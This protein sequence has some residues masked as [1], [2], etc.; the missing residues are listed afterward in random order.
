MAQDLIRFSVA[1]P[2]NLLTRFDALVAKRGLAKNRSEVIRDLVREALA[3][4]ECSL[5][6]EEVI[7]TL[8]IVYDYHVKN[9][10]EKLD[11]IQHEF[12]EQIVTT[13]HI[14]LD[15]SSCMEVIILRGESSL[16]QTASNIILGTKGVT[17]GN[18]A[19]NSTGY[20]LY[21]S[22][23]GGSQARAFAQAHPHTPSNPPFR[24]DYPSK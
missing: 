2:E 13:L 20:S 21:D 19:I 7:G 5:P 17:H 11:N 9:V 10:R 23:Q 15:I 12:Y 18:L 4:E 14:H 3:E 6:G 22:H 8:T 24:G 1:M 16:I